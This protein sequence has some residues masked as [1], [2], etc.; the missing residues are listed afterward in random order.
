MHAFLLPDAM[1]ISLYWLLAGTCC[2]FAAIA[3]GSTGRA[4]AAMIVTA[5]IATAV[6][7]Q[8]GSWGETH[9]PVMIIDLILLAGF[10]WLALRSDSFWPIWAT[11]FHLLSVIGHFA[12]YFS[13]SVR[14]MLYFAFGAFWSLPVLLAMVIGILRDRTIRPRTG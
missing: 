9:L 6:G 4:G 11:G 14:E 13:E 10:Y 7:G 1:I 8:F 5:S 2:A 3:G 12:M